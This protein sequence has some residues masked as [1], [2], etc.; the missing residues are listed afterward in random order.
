MN[1]RKKEKNYERNFRTDKSGNEDLEKTRKKTSSTQNKKKQQKLNK[2]KELEEKA[3]KIMNYAEAQEILVI[4]SDRESS[5]WIEAEESEY[6]SDDS[7]SECESG[8]GR[9]MMKRNP[10]K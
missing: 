5:N 2:K 4:H 6:I 8:E 9:M 10:I 3:R 1:C 7:D